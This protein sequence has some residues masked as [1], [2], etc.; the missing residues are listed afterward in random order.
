MLEDD[1]DLDGFKGNC[2][3]EIEIKHLIH[4][5]TLKLVIEFTEVMKSCKVVK[6]CLKMG[7]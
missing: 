2:G 5:R 4:L 1:S 7:S 6:S 3:L